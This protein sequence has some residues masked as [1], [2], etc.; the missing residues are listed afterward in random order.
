LELKQQ[1]AMLNGGVVITMG[2]FRQRRMSLL[3]LV[4]KF[5]ETHSRQAF[6]A[7]FGMSWL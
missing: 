4:L 6:M 2:T 1:F 5:E 7:I 3:G